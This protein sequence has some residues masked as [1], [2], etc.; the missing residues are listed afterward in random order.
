MSKRS[1]T[2][3]ARSRSDGN[4]AWYMNT[5]IG[6]TSRASETVRPVFTRPIAAWRLA[7]V[8]RFTV[9]FWSSLPQ[10][11]QLLSSLK[12]CSTRSCV[13]GF[14]SAMGL[15]PRERLG[16]YYQRAADPDVGHAGESLLK[17][18]SHA[19]RRRA[20]HRRRVQAVRH[21]AG[22][23]LSVSRWLGHLASP[24]HR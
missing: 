24:G 15:T 5:G 10:R 2:T 14:Q 22:R 20:C 19:H 12:Y 7:A 17:E 4:V 11:P 16:E 23:T 13:G 6:T 21:R 18:E 9:P 8:M 3:S 1:S